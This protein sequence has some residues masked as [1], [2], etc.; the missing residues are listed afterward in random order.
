M[1]REG[2]RTRSFTRRALVVGGAQTGLFG[3]LAG[4]LWSL[5]VEQGARWRIQADENRISERLIAPPRGR[6]LDRLGRPLASNVPTYRVRIVREQAGDVRAV[7]ER[8]DAILSLGAERI[9]EI[10]RQARSLRAFIPVL[11]HEDLT[12]AQV[13]SIAVRS[14]ELPGVVLDS[15]L[16]RQY[17]YGSTVSHILG[18]VGAVGVEELRSDPDPLLQ[19][20]D[21]RIGKTG[22]ERSYEKEL[23]GEAGLLRVEV[24][25]LGREIRE[26]GR[27]EGKAGADLGL[28]LDLDLQRFCFER[29]GEE[30]S[31]SAVV[32]D[33]RSGAVLA[34]VS[35]PSYDPRAFTRGISKPVWQALVRDPFHPLVNKCIRGEYPPG[36]TFKMVTA[37]A[38]LE[39]GVATPGSDV[40]CPGSITLGNA[41]FHCWKSYGH[42]H[43]NLEQALAQS[44]DVYFYELARRVGVDAIA[45]MAGRL[46]LGRPTGIDLPG[47]KGGLAPTRQW[48]RDRL[49]VPWQKGETLILGI[50][51]G[52]ML[53]TPLQ[54]AVMTSRIANGG[55]PVRPWLVREPPV[56]GDEA[57]LPAI[58]PEHLAAVR[59]GMREVV[60][61]PRGTARAAALELPEV[62]MAG[63]TGTSQVRRITKAERA[64]GA[65]K[66]KDR[67]R[68]ERDHALFVC[69]APLDAPRYAVSVIVEHGNSGSATAAPIA[70]DIM[71]RTLELAPGGPLRISAREERRS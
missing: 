44:C 43:M 4:R 31:A 15:G 65:H 32:M 18:Y 64:S 39:A 11:V 26:L 70:R 50:G 55:W 46:G 1:R 25:A 21:F 69:Y 45:A 14:P 5:Q 7:L 54:L 35:V 16:L 51:Q 29:L 66:R 24:N 48:K 2:D 23:R 63:K 60:N 6:I 12:W 13:A 59:A 30:L 71:Q 28:T 68:E 52:F 27:H 42:G 49:G 19:L 38:A 37:L 17:S 9:D 3:L 53:A 67:P 58:A 40:F 56:A 41:R 22:I 10:E 34:M 33:V 36:S 62:M 47:E 57:A 20:P 61:G 8:L